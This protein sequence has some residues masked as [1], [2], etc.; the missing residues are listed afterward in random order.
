MGEMLMK[1]IRDLQVK[2]YGGISIHAEY[3]IDENNDIWYKEDGKIAIKGYQGPNWTCTDCVNWI[4]NART[5]NNIYQC[6]PL[7]PYT[8]K[9]K[10]INEKYPNYD[11]TFK[12]NT[13]LN[14]GHAPCRFFEPK[15]NFNI[16]N[17][18]QFIDI[19]NCCKF[20]YESIQGISK[21]GKQAPFQFS[22]SM[23]EWYNLDFIHDDEVCIFKPIFWN[24]YNYNGVE[25]Y[26]STN[27]HLDFHLNKEQINE[28]NKYIK[29]SYIESMNQINNKYFSFRTM[30]FKSYKG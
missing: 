13:T 8:S 7:S 24:V 15:H 14:C 26:T 23:N 2:K 19:K 21:D 20:T 27:Y 11:I 1:K 10:L 9:C 29:M 12:S 30:W 4:F 5:N 6:R 16:Y 18:N 28:L 22:V 17:I 25:R 3:L